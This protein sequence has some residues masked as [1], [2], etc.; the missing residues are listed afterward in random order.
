[1]ASYRRHFVL[2]QSLQ[3]KE[4]IDC[5]FSQGTLLKDMDP[6]NLLRYMALFATC[7]LALATV[8]LEGDVLRTLPALSEP[9][10]RGFY[11]GLALNC[12]CA[13]ASNL[14]NFLV[15]KY[16]S[17]LTLQVLGQTWTDGQAD[18]CCGN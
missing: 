6:M 4:T 17:P 8:W 12:F 14:T 10:A 3:F 16:T 15:T 1:V 7:T 9:H 5:F 18:K 11:V 13:F 2:L